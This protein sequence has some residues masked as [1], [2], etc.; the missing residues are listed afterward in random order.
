MLTI[1]IVGV[2]MSLVCEMVGAF[3]L[4]NDLNSRLSYN[5]RQIGYRTSWFTHEIKPLDSLSNR[6]DIELIFTKVF[7]KIIFALMQSLLSWINVFLN[8]HQW[9]RQHSESKQMPPSLKELR[10]RLRNVAMP[11]E[12][13][14]KT[15]AQMGSVM[16]GLNQEATD[17]MIAE[18]LESFA[19]R[20]KA[21]KRKDLM[22]SGQ[23]P[24]LADIEVSETSNESDNNDANEIQ[25]KSTGSY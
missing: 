13:V 4:F 3:S 6:L 8:V 16:R 1:Y 24:D 25:K 10:W 22:K 5:L 9:I 17:K 11:A 19:A 23:D 21:I 15:M 14:I 2:I 12:D 18:D 7:I 20:M